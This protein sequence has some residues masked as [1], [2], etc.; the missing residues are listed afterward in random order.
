MPF[1][2]PG[3]QPIS[4]WLNDLKSTLEITQGDLIFALG[5]QAERIRD[6]TCGGLDYREQAFAPYAADRAHYHNPSRGKAIQHASR[7]RAA[8]RHAGRYGGTRTRGGVT[9]KYKSYADF[10][11]SQGVGAVDLGGM[12]GTLIPAI[13]V[14]VGGLH[15]V[16]SALNVNMDSFPEPASEGSFGVYEGKEA[17]I[18]EGHM[19]GQPGHLPQR[20]FLG[21][22][23]DDYNMM[24]EDI[25]MRVNAR[26]ENSI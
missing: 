25:A 21:I 12:Q 26:L 2:G 16:D 13:Q 4:T 20:E 17:L 7:Q 19:L 3:G 5:R 11:N 10:R 8:L 22:N 24:M 15:D 6:R 14:Y 23:D 9:V 1:T 18:A